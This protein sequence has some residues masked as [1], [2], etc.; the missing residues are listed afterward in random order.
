MGD[1]AKDQV[2]VFEVVTCW[3]R[4]GEQ[5]SRIV[6]ASHPWDSNLLLGHTVLDEKI[7]SLDVAVLEGDAFGV[8]CVVYSLVVDEYGRRSIAG[9][10]QLL[11]EETIG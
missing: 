10:F 6:S 7:P 5:V 8:G 4:L 11:K 9:E 2:A 3:E 1:A